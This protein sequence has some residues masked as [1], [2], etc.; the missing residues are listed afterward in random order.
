LALTLQ[1][2]ANGTIVRAIYLDFCCHND[3]F[4]Q[5]GEC[6]GDNCRQSTNGLEQL[7]LLTATEAEVNA[8]ATCM[9]RDLKQHGSRPNAIWQWTDPYGRLIPAPNRFP[10]A[11]DGVG[12]NHLLIMSTVW[13]ALWTPPRLQARIPPVPGT[14]RCTAST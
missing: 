4:C 2:D 10:P 12:F 9:A 14:P 13:V 7:G 6:S 8:N 3:H 5:N 11:A 1:P